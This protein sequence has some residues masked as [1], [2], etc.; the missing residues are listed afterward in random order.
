MII[1]PIKR[2]K[3]EMKFC[4]F[5]QCEHPLTDEWW[6]VRIRVFSGKNRT[7]YVCRAK[8][9]DKC[10]LRY[11]ANKESYR[12]STKK[13]KEAHPTEYANMV[14]RTKAKARKNN[15]SKLLQQERAG[16]ERHRD[17]ERQ[18]AKDYYYANKKEIN[19]KRAE[20]HRT[21]EK[22]R[23]AANLRK[24]IKG[25]FV[26][27]S[28]QSRPKTKEMLGCSWAFLTEYLHQTFFN[29]YGTPYNPDTHIVHI[30]H[31]VPLSSAQTE[32]ELISLCHY[33]NLQLLTAKDNLIKSN[34]LIPQERKNNA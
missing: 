10:H 4:K 1:S 20:K 3:M 6:I 12:A 2:N 16:H 29:K 9:K 15:Y 34:K 26:F 25:F 24:R 23:F 13:W 14:K 19:A 32:Q 27:G 30:D 18:R 17:V 33:S 11:A 22:F 28:R 31:I 5:C 7:E 8:N 21:D